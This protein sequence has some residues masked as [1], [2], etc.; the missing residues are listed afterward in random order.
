MCVCKEL[1]G[2][3]DHV[4]AALDVLSPLSEVHLEVLLSPVGGGTRAH[5]W[6]LQI[7]LSS[8]GNTSVACV[9]LAIVDGKITPPTLAPY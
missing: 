8:I 5:R 7:S 3:D 2:R 1:R 4:N 9:Q 6:R